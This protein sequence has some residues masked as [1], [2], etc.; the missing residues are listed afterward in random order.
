E[1]TAETRVRS[2]PT[3]DLS[4]LS[5]FCNRLFSRRKGSGAMALPGFFCEHPCWASENHGSHLQKGWAD[6]GAFSL[7]TLKSKLAQYRGVPPLACVEVNVGPDVS[8]FRQNTAAPDK[9][10]NQAL[11]RFSRKRFNRYRNLATKSPS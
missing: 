5:Q 11:R 6:A 7:L 4:V 1:R 9:R 3:C 10:A 8:A 2:R